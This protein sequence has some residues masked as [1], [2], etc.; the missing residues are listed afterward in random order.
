LRFWGIISNGQEVFELKI[1]YI[2]EILEPK[3]QDVRIYDR[4]DS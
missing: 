4:E 1:D 3:N 2:F